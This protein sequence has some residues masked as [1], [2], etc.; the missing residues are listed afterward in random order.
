MNRTLFI[1]MLGL[2]GMVIAQEEPREKKA[3][4]KPEAVL[5]DIL[6][7]VEAAALH[8]QTLQEAPASITIITDEE[9]RQ[10]GYRTLAEA[11]ADQRGLYVSF[12]RVY[13]QVGVRGFSIP[14]NANTRFLVMLNGHSLT[15]NIYSSSGYFGEDFGLD[16]D[17]IKQI[18]IIR[19][20]SSALYGANGM[21]AT[22]NVVTKSP[23]DYEPIRMAVQTGSFGERKAQISTS[24]YLGRGANLL[25]S[26]SVFNDA[27]QSLNVPAGRSVDSD[28]DRGYH[29][30]ANLIWQG[31]SFVA[32][33]NSR[34]KVVPN[35]AYGSILNDR[36]SKILD[37]VGFVEAAYQ[38]SVGREG[39]LRWRTSYDQYRSRNRFDFDSDSG[40]F[41]ARQGG[42]GDWL[43]TELTYRFRVAH[44][45]FLTVG[46]DAA[47]DL[48][49]TVFAYVAAPAYQQIA[50]IN[51]RD[52]KLAGFFQQECE[53]S[54]RWKLYLGGRLDGSWQHEASLTPRVALIYQPSPDSALKFLY[55]RSF[56]NPSVFE[57]FYED[58]IAYVS[59]LKLQPERM[60][61][62]E[63]A[64]ERRLSKQ[65]DVS[66][67]AY[68]Y[69]LNDLIAAEPFAPGIEQ[70]R[71]TALAR[72][73]GIEVEA[74]GRIGSRLRAGLSLAVQKSNSLSSDNVR[75][76]SPARVGKLVLD[77]PLF[78]EKFSCSGALQ[79]LSDRKTVLGAHLPPVY[80]VNL[81]MAS[82]KLPNDLELQFGVRNLL[83]RRYADPVSLSYGDSLEQDG[84][85][86]FVRL[87]WAPDRRQD[88]DRRAVRRE[89]TDPVQP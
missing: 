17:L 9:I 54:R 11:L 71:N 88:R 86:V 4:P 3:G 6:P 55:G 25:L 89:R 74:L 30:F 41:D 20:P 65:L 13:R 63:I 42:N 18:E 12:D 46:G 35:G 51:R 72:S 60:Q 19:G 44:V 62:F 21:F 33:F 78:G 26:A 38:R 50:G 68:H 16:M 81:T 1:G 84:R 29:A 43:S 28:G 61:T 49:A 80:L 48:R 40:A 64:F 76:N 56:R 69:R 14:G 7:V 77:A 32:Y 67:N 39:Q 45:G 37:G 15:D 75:A 52:R 70:Y 23:V 57:E 27:G 59:N 87:A 82:R 8:T 34:E 22:I 53:L 47:W 66:A 58:A 36:G 83:D 2:T 79:Y 73:T 10:R 24:Q 31:W 85:S 5:F